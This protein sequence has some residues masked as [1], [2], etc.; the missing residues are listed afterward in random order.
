MARPPLRR[1]GSVLDELGWTRDELAAFLRENGIEPTEPQ[2]RP[3]Q[4]IRKGWA[5][6]LPINPREPD[7]DG[8]DTA[9]PS[10]GRVGERPPSEPPGARQA[11][12]PV[13]VT[14]LAEER[15]SSAY[16]MVG[17]GIAMGSGNERIA[18][19]FDRYSDPIASAWVKA[20]EENEFAKRVVQFM[21]AGGATGELVT[22]H[23][24][25]VGGLLYVTGRAPALQG[26]YG[27]TLGAPPVVVVGPPERPGDGADAAAGDAVGDAAG[28]AAA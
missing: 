20:A 10:T 17:G 21:S 18:H 14:Q 9:D 23:L 22:T 7:L 4:P 13:S 28:A 5:A 16:K 12:L 8:A 6:L 1:V 26:L 2:L 3:S 25:L 27:R 11:P 19:V 15:I 24:I